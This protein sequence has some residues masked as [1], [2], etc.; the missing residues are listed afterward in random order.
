[1]KENEMDRKNGRAPEKIR[2]KDVIA[3]SR[4]LYAL[5]DVSMTEQKR[6]WQQDR[7]WNITQKLTGMP[8]GRGAPGGLDALFA[9]ISEIEEQYEADCAEY[10]R[11][12][13]TA[14]AIINSIP[15]RTMRTFVTMKYMLDM[16]NQQIMTRLNMGR[17][18]FERICRDIEQAPDMASVQWIERYALEETN[19]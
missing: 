10:L 17:K 13:Q 15:S 2:N 1:M 7:I 11:E 19:G 3:L 12:L 14:E 16:P 6:L 4:V 5:Q 8:G 18:S 9:A